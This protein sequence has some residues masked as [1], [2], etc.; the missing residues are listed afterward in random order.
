MAGSCPERIRIWQFLIS[1]RGFMKK[2]NVD[3][4]TK[5]KTRGCQRNSF[6]TGLRTAVKIGLVNI[7]FANSF[8]IELHPVLPFYHGNLTF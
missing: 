5:T 1:N 6:A 7:I 8:I 3:K 2:K 4:L